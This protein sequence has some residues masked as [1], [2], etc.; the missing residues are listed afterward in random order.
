NP[1]S[2]Q[3]IRA[4]AQ[5][6]T[7]GPPPLWRLV[8]RRLSLLGVLTTEPEHQNTRTPE[9]QNDYQPKSAPSCT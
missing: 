8:H 3:A 6:S 1:R 9:H 5:D 2:G 7:R 4:Q